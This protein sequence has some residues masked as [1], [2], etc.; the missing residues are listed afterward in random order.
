V[1]HGGN[2]LMR[3]IARANARLYGAA[4]RGEDMRRRTR[5]ALWA[6]ALIF[7]CPGPL[8]A[9][10]APTEV[11]MRETHAVLLGL[12]QGGVRPEHVDGADIYYSIM[13][14]PDAP[15][16]VTR[17]E[18]SGAP[19]RARTTSALQ[20]PEKWAILTLGLVD[21]GRVT[22]VAAYASIDDMIGEINPVPFD[23]PQAAQIV[24]T[25][26]GLF[27]SSRMAL[28]GESGAA[29][30]MCSDRLDLSMMDEEQKARGKH[31]LAIV[32]KFCKAP[33]FAR[34]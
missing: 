33:A 23:A 7:A 20:F 10:D 15:R 31:A 13:E 34:K 14:S 16:L 6:A 25:G 24:L 29:D 8:T 4:E 12:A 2:T 26:E 3:R 30:H 11:E 1:N 17:L 5:T 9:Q 27:C 28:S 22:S 21:L 19:C 18:V 32:A